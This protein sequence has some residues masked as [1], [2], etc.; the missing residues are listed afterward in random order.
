MTEEFTGSLRLGDLELVIP[1]LSTLP[2]LPWR[3]LSPGEVREPTGL[4]Q[5]RS[6]GL[7]GASDPGLS[8]RWGGT[9]L[10]PDSPKVVREPPGLV[11]GLAPAETAAPYQ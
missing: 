6:P 4:S 5:R 7:V 1:G 10:L 9:G 11:T 2:G 3:R 8:Q